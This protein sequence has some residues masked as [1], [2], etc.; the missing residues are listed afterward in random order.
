ME[1][2]TNYLSDSCV[3]G[4]DDPPGTGIR[5]CVQVHPNARTDDGKQCE[6]AIRTR[7]QQQQ[8]SH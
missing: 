3:Q 5:D 4:C 7:D 6:L 1:K 2:K 8:S